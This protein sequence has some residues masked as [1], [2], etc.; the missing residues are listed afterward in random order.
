MGM[1][2][3][4]VEAMDSF[5]TSDSTT[6]RAPE[7]EQKEKDSLKEGNGNTI[8]VVGVVVA[9]VGCL[10][11]GSLAYFRF[12]RRRRGC[13]LPEKNLENLEAGLGQQGEIPE[14]HPTLL[15]STSQC[16][17]KKTVMEVPPP[18]QKKQGFS[19]SI[20]SVS[21][22]CASAASMSAESISTVGSDN[23]MA[24]QPHVDK[25][26]L[27]AISQGLSEISEVELPDPQENMDK[28]DLDTISEGLPET[29][30]VLPD[31][32]KNRSVVAHGI[33]PAIE[34]GEIKIHS[35]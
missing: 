22:V 3:E 21:T 1:M 33:L 13:D 15:T 6:T 18:F 27:H 7:Q 2:V 19:E 35:I 20:T 16:F 5:I 14:M 23:V 26:D 29:T 30:L 24:V 4:E 12:T 31:S 28:Q 17:T 32:Q 25:Q 11:F 9:V 10:A 8:V 34:I